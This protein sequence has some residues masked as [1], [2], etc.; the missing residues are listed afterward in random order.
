MPPSMIEASDDSEAGLGSR[1]A[2]P[3]DPIDNG[4]CLAN[5]HGKMTKPL[6]KQGS[7][8]DSVNGAIEIKTGEKQNNTQCDSNINSSNSWSY[9]SKMENNAVPPPVSNNLESGETANGDIA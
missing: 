7:P 5:G 8:Q 3:V 4:S 9:D 1:A 2:D 6:P